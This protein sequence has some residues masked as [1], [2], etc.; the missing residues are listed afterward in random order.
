MRII[1]GQ[2]KGHSIITGTRRI[3]L[4]AKK[5]RPTTARLRAAVFNII[6]KF[7]AESHDVVMRN[8]KVLDIC[9]GI[10]SFGLEAL[11][12][13]AEKVSFI[14]NT[15]IH[16]EIVRM[17]LEK[18]K[19]LDKAQLILT[20]AISLSV[21]AEV[22]DLVY[23]DPPYNTSYLNKIITSLITGAWIDKKTMIIIETSSKVKEEKL[24]LKLLEKRNYGSSVLSFYSL[25]ECLL[26]SKVSVIAR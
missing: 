21:S 10:G 4:D 14:D 22:Y 6:P 26:P 25:S 16:L 12:R 9:C 15:R 5:I 8:K 17:N 23:I 11:S 13:N 24:D 2:Y 3:K 18:L 19:A 20:D 1:A 7:F